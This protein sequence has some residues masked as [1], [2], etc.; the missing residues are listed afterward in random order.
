MA[1][2]SCY[3]SSKRAAETLA[4]CYARQYGLDVSIARPSHVYGP[5]FSPS[6]NRVYA[7]FIRNVLAGEDIVMKSK[8]TQFRSWCYVIDC[9]AALLFLLLKG[10]N[11]TAYN[12]A[13]AQSNITIR[14]LAEL[15]EETEKAGYSVVTKAVFDTARLESLGW[16]P[17]PS[18]MQEKIK[19]TLQEQKEVQE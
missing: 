12:I 17:L 8:G 5:Y 4:V 18:P 10:E 11:M 15:P 13:D 2:R 16:S 3:P 9:A 14:S 1:V 7:Q 6:D 19:A